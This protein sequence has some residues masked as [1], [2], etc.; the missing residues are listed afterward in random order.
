MLEAKKKTLTNTFV[1]L[2]NWFAFNLQNVIS[3]APTIFSQYI[4]WF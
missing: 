2:Q 3:N 4:L 1:F